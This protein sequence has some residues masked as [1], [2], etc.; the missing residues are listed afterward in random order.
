MQRM[1]AASKRGHG[2]ILG[3][4]SAKGGCGATTVCCHLAVELARRARPRAERPVLLTGL[5]ASGG[6][7]QFI[8]KTAYAGLEVECPR[9]QTTPDLEVIRTRYEWAVIDLGSGLNARMLDVLKHVHELYVVATPDVMA[10]HQTKQI[11]QA[12]S[13]NHYRRERIRLVFNRLWKGADENL[14]EAVQKMSGLRVCATLPNDYQAHYEA[15]L[16]GKLLS[17]RSSFAKHI[18]RLVNQITGLA[19]DEPK[20]ALSIFGRLAPV[21]G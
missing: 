15:V 4:V 13:G 17:P 8:M 19:E 16:Q 10:L 1:I 5:D 11:A 20:G 14:S 18:A 3:F 2:T 9:F 21:S 6:S 7:L 12:L